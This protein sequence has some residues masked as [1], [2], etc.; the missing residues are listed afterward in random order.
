ML[1]RSGY[2]DCDRK[3]EAAADTIYRIASITKLFTSTAIVQLR[4]AGQLQLDDPIDKHLSW[5]KIQNRHADAPPITIRHLLTH[6]AGLPRE[7]DFPYWNDSN[8]PTQTQMRERLTH[9][10]TILPTETRWKY[11][12]LGLTLAG[13]IVEAISGQPYVEYIRHR[14]LEPLEMVDTFVETVPADHPKL[15]TGYSRRLPSG[16]R[17][18]S[19][20]TDCRAITP[21]ANMASTVE[22]LARFAMLQ[23]R[24][25]AEGGKQVLRGSSLR[26]MQRVHWLNEDWS[27][28]RG[29][30]FYVWRKN[31]KTLVGH[32]GALQ[33]YRT[34]FQLCPEDKI[35]IIVL[36]NADDGTPLFYF[37]KA[38]DW[39]APAL[40]SA[41]K[42]TKKEAS[43]D[44][45]WRQYVGKYRNPWADTQVM[46]LDGELVAL[47]PSQPDPKLA[48]NKLVPVGEHT[49]RIEAQN[50][51]AAE[52]E[53]AVFEMDGTGQVARVKL[54]S[55]YTYPVSE[56]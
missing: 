29:L 42:E 33:G 56:W 34:E 28:G 11:S 38:F 9:Q 46:V 48:I 18:C 25:G 21:A 32:G 53:L 10:E 15:A 3:I 4:D 26:E 6:T 19:P 22:D 49:F 31:G 47:D 30:G 2:A 20:Y 7:A 17:K 8:F 13:E 55:T 14:I 50:N 16:E 23:F 44:P 45:T 1:F 43:P 39:V 5:L 37:E 40:V 41:A 54:G 27:A 12:N 36:T 52:G 35:A 24:D 51:F